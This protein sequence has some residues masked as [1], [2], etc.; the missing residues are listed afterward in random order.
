M[1]EATYS[2]G[3][4]LLAAP[5][6]ALLSVLVAGWLM[7]RRAICR[8]IGHSWTTAGHDCRWCQDCGLVQE[9]EGDIGR[10]DAPH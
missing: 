10:D 7:P 9:Y 4:L 3:Q 8:L 2:L 1:T 5:L 6:L